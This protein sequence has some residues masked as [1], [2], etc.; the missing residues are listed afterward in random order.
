MDGKSKPSI[1]SEESY[2]NNGIVFVGESTVTG[3]DYNG[4][5]VIIESK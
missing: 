5:K 1:R 3:I 2:K 4:K